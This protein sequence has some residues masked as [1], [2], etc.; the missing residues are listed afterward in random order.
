M[1]QYNFIGPLQPG[2]SRA[3]RPLDS[4]NCVKLAFGTYMK[5][6]EVRTILRE[7]YTEI[8]CDKDCPC[9]KLKMWYYKVKP[10]YYT[11]DKKYIGEAVVPNF[12]IV[13]GLCNPKYVRAKNGKGPES[14]ATPESQMKKLGRHKPIF[15][16]EDR[17]WVEEIVTVKTCYCES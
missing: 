1:Y 4:Y 2:D 7:K 17:Q 6:K 12:H 8:D 11:E 10:H 5:I 16:K 9:E 14:I 3:A 15:D 13:G